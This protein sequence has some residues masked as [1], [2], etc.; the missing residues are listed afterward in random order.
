[1]RKALTQSQKA[2]L[3]AYQRDFPL[4]SRPF[5]AI[6][7]ELDLTETEV[8]QEI[9][10]LQERDIVSRVGATVKPNRA[11]ASTLAAMAV[12]AARLDEVA[13]VVS[14]Q[15]E[16]NHNY[17]REHRFNLW[18][19]VT[20]TDRTKLENALRRIEGLTGLDIM[21]LPLEKPYHVDLGFRL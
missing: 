11:G 13:A 14:A 5:D 3:N 17:E 16:V 15:P 19:V 2:I 8:I 4:T 6:G 18:F 12:P 21:P 1:M 10:D 20:T 9:A 7:D